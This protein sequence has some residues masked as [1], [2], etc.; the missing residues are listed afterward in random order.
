MKA[1]AG[2]RFSLITFG[3]AQVAMDIEPLVR[4]IRGDRILHGFTHTYIGAAVVGAGVLILGKPLAARLNELWRRELIREGAAW[5][6]ESGGLDSGPAAAG[7]FI[8]T[9]SHVALDSLMHADIRPFAPFSQSND[10]LGLIPLGELHALCVVAGIVGLVVWGGLRYL[11]RPAPNKGGTGVN[12]CVE[13]RF[14]GYGTR[15]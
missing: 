5:L 10:L 8:G 1:L 14:S 4:M 12:G 15:F 3:V 7:A 9:L 11:H 2:R 13:P 6:E